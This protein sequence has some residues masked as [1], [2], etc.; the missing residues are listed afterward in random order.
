M[1]I[2]AD[3]LSKLIPEDT[4]VNIGNSFENIHTLSGDTGTYEDELF[5]YHGDHLSSNQMITDINANITQQ[6]LYAP[7][8]EILTE[9]NAYW[10][11]GKIPDYQFN[12]KE[13]DEE[14]GLYYYSARYYN[15]PTFISRDPLFEKYPFM[16]SY[17][18]CANNPVIRVDPD[19]RDW[20]Q[21]QMAVEKAKEY[22][23]KN[24]GN[25]YALGGRGNPGGMT[26]CSGM[27]S[28]TIMA[29]GEPDPYTNHTGRGVERIIQ[30]ST[31][32]E[33]VNDIEAGNVM[34]FNT[35]KQK[36]GHIGLISDVQ[37]DSDGNTIGVTIIDSGGDPESGKSGPRY[38]Q[39]T[40]GGKKYWD[41]KIEGVYKWDTIPDTTYE[42]G[43]LPNVDV[44]AQRIP[45]TLENNRI[46]QIGE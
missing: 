12:A 22:V 8:G 19:G 35:D 1:E 13:K 21:R 23:A 11:Q 29:G 7:F 30:A 3:E 18:Y 25:T 40:F 43:T 36:R 45:S 33:N 24:S 14:S 6:I 9:Y 2:L 44:E 27:V 41:K 37:K 31:P 34:V 4:I 39:V 42:G 5:F 15:P 26:D 28:R 38:T 46:N 16:S 20:R 17:S 10:H 32:V